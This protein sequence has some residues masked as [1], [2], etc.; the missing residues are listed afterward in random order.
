MLAREACDKLVKSKVPL[1]LVR[2]HEICGSNGCYLYDELND[3]NLDACP[4]C[5]GSR[6]IKKE[7]TTVKI[8][9]KI[10][11]LIACDS[12]RER[13][14]Y[15]SNKYPNNKILQQNTLQ[16]KVYTDAFDGELF[17]D[18]V[19]RGYFDN[20]FDIALKIDIDGFQSKFSNTKMTMIHCVILNYD[21]SEVS[22]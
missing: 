12:T 5:H 6:E 9:E 19:K 15:R 7:L 13:L 3:K 11:E 4:I 16:R 8:A 17:T 20:Q 2:R 1:Q 21:I 10:A 14:A 18:F 22:V